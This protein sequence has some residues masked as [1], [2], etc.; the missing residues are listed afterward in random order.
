MRYGPDLIEQLKTRVD[1]LAEVR[2][3]LPAIKK[4]GR[5]WWACCP[6]HNEKSPSFHVRPEQNSY[7]CFGC[8]A[9]GDVIS[10]VQETQGG[11]FTEVVERLAQQVGLA[12]PK[13]TEANPQAQAEREQGYHALARAA[14]FFSRHLGTAEARTAQAYVQKRALSDAT[15][16]EFQLG[17]APAG[18]TT[19]ADALATEGFSPALLARAGLTTTSEKN[20][21]R[22][23][24]RFRQ[25]LMFPIQDA[26]G[27]VIGFGGRVLDGSEPKYLNSP[28]TPWF[29]KSH[30]LFN[31]HRVKPQVRTVGAL[32]LV[33]GYMD[34]IALWQAGFKAAVAP[35]G[36][37]VTE[38]QLELLWRHHPLPTVCLDGDAAGRTAALRAAQRA[39]PLLTPER[40]LQ[41]VFLPQGEDPD[42]LVRQDGLGAFRQLLSQPQ[43]LEHV[44]W[45]HLSTLADA[46]TAAGKAT[47]SAAI[48]ELVAA[49]QNATVRQAYGQALRD[50]L[51]HASRSHTGGSRGGKPVAPGVVVATAVQAPVAYRPGMAPD[52]TVRT[53]LAM[54]CRWPDVLASV[55]EDVGNWP[56]PPGPLA[57]LRQH[58]LRAVV[59][60]T[61][62]EELAAQLPEGPHAETV[63]DLLRSTGVQAMGD[64]TAVARTFASLHQRWQAA[65]TQRQQQHSLTR[66][67]QWFDPKFWRKFEEMQKDGSQPAALPLTSPARRP[68]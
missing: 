5:H 67:G 18:W 59:L 50:K 11:S 61:P 60:Q 64:D 43:S 37:A 19:T 13:A 15:I 16:T 10:F 47:I 29:S 38:D 4:K 45:Q 49:V 24:D 46:T 68:I 28:E 17:L 36:T 62:P 21:G 9:T 56:L 7:Y 51:Y 22:A 57:E 54:L 1:L 58:L 25:R 65:Q 27:R 52:A 53:L 66:T 33:E 14:V 8:G 2:K 39:L 42:S 35:L 32:V 3:V 31:L 20:P 12:L 6:F 30:T 55:A 41:F 26:Q 63:A 40:N 34:V 48:A 44:L 23:Y